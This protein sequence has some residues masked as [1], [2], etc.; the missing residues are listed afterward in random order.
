MKH[1]LHH[2]LELLESDLPVIISVAL[3]DQLAPHLVW[4]LLYSVL[5]VVTPV[6]R[7]LVACV[8]AQ[9]GHYEVFT[10]QERFDF[11]KSDPPVLINVKQVEGSL[12]LLISE[13]L[14]QLEVCGEELGIVN[15]AIPIGVHTLQN[16]LDLDLGAVSTSIELRIA[17]DELIFT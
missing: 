17:L 7:G 2:C 9:S 1:L 13:K 15:R 4:V 16:K 10:A 12:Q 14:C 8:P 6:L 5:R 3:P 11:F